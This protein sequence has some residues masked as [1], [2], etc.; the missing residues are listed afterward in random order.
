MKCYCF[1]DVLAFEELTN[2]DQINQNKVLWPSWTS[3]SLE[4]S[5]PWW[6][7]TSQRI[8]QWWKLPKCPVLT[9]AWYKKSWW[10]ILFLHTFSRT[11]CSNLVGILWWMCWWTCLKWFCAWLSITM[12]S[13]PIFD[14]YYFSL[15]PQ[16]YKEPTFHNMLHHSFITIW[17]WV[18]LAE[19]RKTNS[20][21]ILRT[22]I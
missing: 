4:C 5:T 20:W 18:D 1:W 16:R 13:Y 17:Q 14:Y 7:F 3:I 21:K 11:G 8:V 12:I 10:P 15:Y 9:W 2:R 22:S 6:V 19:D